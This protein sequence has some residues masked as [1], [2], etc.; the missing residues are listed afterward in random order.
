MKELLMVL[1]TVSTFQRM[2][3]TSNESKIAWSIE[4]SHTR[5]AFTALNRF[6][7]RVIAKNK[8]E[9]TEPPFLHEIQLFINSKESKAWS[10]AIGNQKLEREWMNLPPNEEMSIE[11]SS[12]G[13][14]LFQQPGLYNLSFKWKNKI[15]GKKRIRVD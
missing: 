12:L 4:T 14:S 13:N 2:E 3:T 11:L 7:V 6:K 5:I 8:G 15:I 1:L 9:D 10:L